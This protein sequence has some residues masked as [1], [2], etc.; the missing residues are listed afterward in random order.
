MAKVES[1]IPRREKETL[2][3]ICGPSGG[4][5]GGEF[6]DELKLI[7]LKLAPNHRVVRV[8]IRTGEIV[9]FVQII[10]ILPDNDTLVD[11]DPHGGSGGGQQSLDLRADERITQIDGRY[12]QLVDSINIRT[13]QGRVLSGGGG[14]GVQGY[15]YQAPPGLQIVGFFGRSGA[16][17]DAIGIVLR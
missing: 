12:G 7:D 17:M 3:P 8:V 9:D 14:G 15:L 2:M 16:V 1:N 11:L 4:G 6:N 5:G 13:N 10:H